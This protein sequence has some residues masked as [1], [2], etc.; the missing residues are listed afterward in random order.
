MT[1]VNIFSA[2]EKLS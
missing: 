2:F 1:I